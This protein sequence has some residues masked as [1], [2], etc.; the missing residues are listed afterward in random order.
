MV[1]TVFTVVEATS[2]IWRR[3]REDERSFDLDLAL[4]TL[5]DFREAFLEITDVVEVTKQACMLFRRHAMKAADAMQLANV[6]VLT[7]GSPGFLPFVTLDGNLA[8]AA[9]AEGL[10]V[11]NVNEDPAS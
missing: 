2:A 8:R 3:W 1:V 5:A 9:R 11:I 7:A 10:T 6:L 4:R